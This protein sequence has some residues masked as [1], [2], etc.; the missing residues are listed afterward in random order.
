[1]HVHFEL[2]VNLI[3]SL[4]ADSLLPMMPGSPHAAAAGARQKSDTRSS[5]THRNLPTHRR[6]LKMRRQFFKYLRKFTDETIGV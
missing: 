3:P 2:L 1:V 4:H 5:H 6:K